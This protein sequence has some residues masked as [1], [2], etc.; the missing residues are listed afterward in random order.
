MQVEDG[1]G[2]RRTKKKARNSVGRVRESRRSMAAELVSHTCD[3]F[4]SLGCRVRVDCVLLSSLVRTRTFMIEE[5]DPPQEIPV[6]FDT[7]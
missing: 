6:M 1:G 2:R 5:R 3:R 7:V 4:F